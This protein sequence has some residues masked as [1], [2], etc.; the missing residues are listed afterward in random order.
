[1]SQ[2]NILSVNAFTI[3][4]GKEKRIEI[5]ST[6]WNIWNYRSFIYEL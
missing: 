4:H 1:M 2:K 6:Y 3:H 5:W